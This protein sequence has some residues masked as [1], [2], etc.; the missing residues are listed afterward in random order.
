MNLPKIVRHSN[1]N[2]KIYA[3]PKRDNHICKLPKIENLPKKL[4]KLDKIPSR[5]NIRGNIR[6]RDNYYKNIAVFKDNY[7]SPYR[8]NRAKKNYYVYN[9]DA[10]K[11]VFNYGY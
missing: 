11:A 9:S 8:Y 1:V 7:V 5:N 4:P 10:I 6:G 3:K 2:N